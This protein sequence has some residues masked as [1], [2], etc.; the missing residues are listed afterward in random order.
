MLTLHQLEVTIE[1]VTPLALDAYCGSALRGA[2]FRALWGRFCTN[3]EAVT[4]SACALNTAC[5][6]ST[7][8]APLRNEAPRGRDVPR[9]YIITPLY[10]EKEL[11]APGERCSFCLTL[12]GSAAK[13][14]PYAVRALLEMEHNTLGHPRKELQGKRG[15]FLLCTIDAVHP[16]TQ[17]R[18]SL[19]QQGATRPE[20]LQLGISAHDVAMR[21][22]QLPQDALTIQFLSPTRLVSGAQ[23]LRRPDLSTLVQRL[24]ER[25]EQ[26]QQ[27]YGDGPQDQQHG[28]EW[29]LSLKEQAARMTLEQDETHWVDVHSYSARQHQRISIGGIVG[30]ASYHGPLTDL[31]ELL[32]WGEILRVG[33]N[34]VKGAGFYRIEM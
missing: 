33:K 8:V 11:Y 1:A 29:Y 6:V 4:C 23:V 12:I 10:D 7:L 32:V 16:F 30:K 31:R 28:R 24:A 5:P 13:L 27:E 17:Q 21:A 25:L 14:Y 2:F 26:V 22:E 34:I 15:R 19:W 20:K 9:P 18:I 3:R